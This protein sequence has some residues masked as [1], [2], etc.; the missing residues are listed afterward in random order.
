[1]A[2]SLFVPKDIT[3]DLVELIIAKKPPPP[4]DDTNNFDALALSSMDA[5]PS[6]FKKNYFFADKLFLAL[7]SS[8]DIN[9]FIIRSRWINFL[10]NN[11]NSDFKLE[12]CLYDLWER[13]LISFES[14][15]IYSESQFGSADIYHKFATRS[16]DKIT[17]LKKDSEAK[18]ERIKFLEQ[19]VDVQSKESKINAL[20][21]ALEIKSEKNVTLYEKLAQ[22]YSENILLHSKEK[23]LRSVITRLKSSEGMVEK[24]T[25]DHKELKKDIPETIFYNGECNMIVGQLKTKKDIDTKI[26]SL[27]CDIK[28]RDPHKKWNNVVDELNEKIERSK[29]NVERNR[30]DLVMDELNKLNKN[31]IK[32]VHEGVSAK[33]PTDDEDW[34]KIII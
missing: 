22:V 27:E 34:E 5:M 2:A 31:S 19:T 29:K 10:G 26:V 18:D 7:C 8:L 15:H 12:N 1:M 28:K 13:S 21:E 23:F 11:K 25:P 33:V 4:S 14:I 9:C 30:W 6:E 20:Q 32:K 24:K 3:E 16:I 17:M